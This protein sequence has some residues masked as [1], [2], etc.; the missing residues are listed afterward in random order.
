MNSYKEAKISL[1]IIGAIMFVVII[2]Y[3][4]ASMFTS[5]GYKGLREAR[6]ANAD[7]FSNYKN[8]IIVVDA[9]HGGEDPGAT[10]NGLVE[11]DLNLDI[12]NRLNQMLLS[13]GYDTLLTRSEDVLLYNPNEE[14]RKKYHDLRNREAI[15][16]NCENAL[17]VSIHMNKFPLEACKGLQTFYSDN[18]TESIKIAQSIQE[19]AKLLQN[20]NNREVKCG[21][22]TI[23]LMKNLDMPAVLIECGFISN[24]EEASLL[25]DSKYRDALV[26]SIYC[27][28]SEYLEEVEN[29]T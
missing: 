17:F 29:E 14:G 22:D 13:F 6:D 1:Y 5:M 20:Y 3:F 7:Q 27:G 28:L 26:F 18:N 25:S 24:T 9:G 19:N 12:A 15:A 2:F 10:A 21:N 4:V 11:K 16:E 8:V 23:Y